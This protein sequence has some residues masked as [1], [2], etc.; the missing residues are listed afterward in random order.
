MTT[1]QI[2]ASDRIRSYLTHQAGKS[3]QAIRDLVQKGQSQLLDTIEG[4]SEEQAT[5]KPEPD[6]WSV[7]EVL[8]HVE[9]A[10]R[11]VVKICASLAQGETPAGFGGEGE[12]RGSETFASLAEARAAI[13]AP[14]E[15]L[16]AF[17]ETLPPAANVESRYDHFI[18]G[19]LNGRE[20]AAFQ[21]VHDGDHANQIEQVKASPGYPA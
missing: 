8:H 20:W 16:L 17:I 15:E 14:H 2:E 4:L 3:P 6:V 13:E 7:L 12:D 5:F 21:R 18:F 9:R 11:G 1:E 19:A 10:K